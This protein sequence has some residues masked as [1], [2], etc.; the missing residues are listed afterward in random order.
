M[1]IVAALLSSITLFSQETKL[2]EIKFYDSKQIQE[3]YSVLK[4]NKQ[5]KHGEYVSYFKMNLDQARDLKNGFYKLEQ[6]IRTKGAYKNGK[7][8]GEWLEYD[9]PFS[10]KTKGKYVEDKRTGVWA[11][12]KENGQ[13]IE[14]YDHDLKKMLPPIIKVNIDYPPRAREMGIQGG[15][16]GYSY[17]I[18]KD[19]SISDV[20]ITKKFNDE[21]DSHVIAVLK[22]ISELQMRYSM[23][24]EEKI[25]S[26]DIIFKL[27]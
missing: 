21:F 4:S 17:R 25:V 27:E 3:R 6:F 13:V 2:L 9:R 15:L 12:T 16:V 26:Q 5:I 1:T 14:N 18:N 24:C 20:K 23:V 8:D 7:K 11:T 10:L 19:C 22:R